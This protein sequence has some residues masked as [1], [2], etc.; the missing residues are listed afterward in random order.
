MRHHSAFIKPTDPPQPLPGDGPASQ[1]GIPSADEEKLRLTQF[2]IDHCSDAAY[3]MTGDGTIFYVNEQ[4][5]KIL[6]YSPQ[7]L[8]GMTIYDIDPNFR[9]DTWVDHWQVL[10]ESR[11][12]RLES[13]HRTKTGHNIPVDIS[14]NYVRFGDREYYCA[15]AR[16]L[17]EHLRIQRKNREYELRLSSAQ[18]MEALGTLAGGIAHDFNNILSS[19]LGF[20]ELAME[21]VA[22]DNPVSDHVREIYTAGLRAKELVNQILTFS[23][24]SEPEKQPIQLKLIVKEVLKLLRA[25]IPTTINIRTNIRSNGLV[26][27][28]PSQLHQIL[29]NLATNARHAMQTDGGTLTVELT[30][31]DLGPDFTVI[32]P[33]IEPGRYLQ[34]V[35]AD[36]GNGIAPEDIGRIFDPFFTTKKHGE[37]TGLGLSVVHGIV[38]EH[39]G[40]ITVQS[41]PGQGARFQV[42]LPMLRLNRRPVPVETEPLPT[43]DERILLVDDEPAIVNMVSQV[44]KRLGYGVTCRTSAI[45]A[46]GLFRERSDQFDLVLT[47]LTMPHL[48]GNK[49]AAEILAI[50]ADI[51]VILCTGY[52]GEISESAI[53]ELGIKELIMKPILKKT[54][55]ITLRKVLDT[56]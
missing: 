53:R 26:M 33:E 18:R 29:M 10:R 44:L 31:V 6:G 22:S 56:K 34:L 1:P 41:E 16:D 23:R 24:Q 42:Y 20:S 3:W 54:L 40:T 19:I 45:E 9:Q 21:C 32:H 17:T 51:P 37:G 2:A 27:A 50:R 49:L 8:I 30:E 11:S 39:G 43:G 55:A 15:F 7:E 36:T 5:C 38:C 35:V 4:V 14:A 25:S 52:S 46:L 28:D 48:P 47:D 13:V 12:L